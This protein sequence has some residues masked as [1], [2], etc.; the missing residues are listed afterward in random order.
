MPLEGAPA[1]AG[2]ALLE[3]DGS[4]RAFGFVVGEREQIPGPT[5][6][7]IVRTGQQRRTGQGF[8][9]DPHRRPRSSHDVG[10]LDGHRRIIPTQG[11]HRPATP[12]YLRDPL[13]RGDIGGGAGRTSATCRRCRPAARAPAQDQLNMPTRTRPAPPAPTTPAE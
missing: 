8:R 11:G 9:T 1:A 3:F 10:V 5:D 12:A 2:G 6:R 13:I 4:D 7:Q